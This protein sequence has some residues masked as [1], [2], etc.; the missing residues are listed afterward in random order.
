MVIID[1]YRK[2]RTIR[3]TVPWTKSMSPVVILETVLVA[4]FLKT[5]AFDASTL[6]VVV[7]L[8]PGA[9][10]PLRVMLVPLIDNTEPT[11][12]GF[13]GGRSAP[14]C[15]FLG[16]AVWLFVLSARAGEETKITSATVPIVT[17][18]LSTIF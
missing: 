2:T 11:T 6:K 4:R 3:V 9:T 5:L 7:A 14:M 1:H 15:I 12:A 8:L 18:F 13:I 17:I 10:R 16:L